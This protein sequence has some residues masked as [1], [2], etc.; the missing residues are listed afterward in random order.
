[1]SQRYFDKTVK[2]ELTDVYKVK[3][4]LADG[5][6]YDDVEMR[7]LFPISD[8]TN[9][10]SLIDKDEHEIG[11]IRSYD[12]LSPESAAAVKACFNDYYLIPRITKV[13]ECDM[14][15][16]ML[17]IVAD[18]DHG[19]VTFRVRNRLNDMKFYDNNRVLIRDADDNRYEIEDINR[20]DRRSWYLLSGML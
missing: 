20:L 6:V 3:L 14:K 11:I 1:M 10:I 8:R 18:T 17:R 19:K 13:H 16:G 4:T 5:T 7:C 9:Y 2:I 15:T 12:D